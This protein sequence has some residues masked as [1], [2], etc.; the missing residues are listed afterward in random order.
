MPSGACEASRRAL[1]AFGR[2]DPVGA[3][4]GRAAVAQ[5]SLGQLCQARLGTAGAC[6]AVVAALDAFGASHADAAHSA[7]L[8][9]DIL[10]MP[11][12]F[13]CAS[14]CFTFL[15][16]VATAGAWLVNHK[17]LLAGGAIPTAPNEMIV[18]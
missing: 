1:R 8:P 9:V 6:D 4:R 15:L 2:L 11:P 14:F 16:L 18:C 5:L 3:F 7:R 13:M 10:A 12:N 17:A